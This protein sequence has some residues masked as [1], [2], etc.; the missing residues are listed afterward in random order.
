MKLNEEQKNKAI[1]T[2]SSFLKTPCSVCESKDW[3]LNDTIFELREF[4]GGGL[5]IGG[6]S[7]VFPVITVI[8]KHCGNTLFF[9]AIQLGLIQKEKEDGQ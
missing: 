3:I 8:C 1:D 2:L 5:V 7:S 4:Q 9:N 6:K